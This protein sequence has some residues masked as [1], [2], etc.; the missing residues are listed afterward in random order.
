MDQDIDYSIS[1]ITKKVKDDLYKVMKFGEKRIFTVSSN[2]IPEKVMNIYQ[3]QLATYDGDITQ[4]RGL[5]EKTK[6]YR[7]TQASG[8][9]L[10]AAVTREDKK[11]DILQELLST[12]GYYVNSVNFEGDTPLHL[13]AMNGNIDALD[14]LIKNF[15]AIDPLSASTLNKQTPLHYAITYNKLIA[16][17]KLIANGASVCLQDGDGS[18]AFHIAVAVSSPNLDILDTL[19]LAD[20]SK[21]TIALTLRD[22]KGQTP[23]HEAILNR[24]PVEFL[25]RL[26]SSKVEI[27]NIKDD[28]GRT[29]L[30]FA[31]YVKKLDY[32][33]VLLKG[34]ASKT[35]NINLQD[36][37]GCTAMHYAVKDSCSIAIIQYLHIQGGIDLNTIKDKY[38]K[39]AGDYAKNV[40]IKNYFKNPPNI[41]NNNNNNNTT[42]VPLVITNST[43][44][45]VSSSTSSSSS[46]P[47][48]LDSLSPAINLLYVIA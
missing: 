30:H 25:T 17:K 31:V 11:V 13:A 15:A 24:V 10:C 26:L 2:Q 27:V 32:L 18:T 22:K 47:S 20:S 36:E 23:L 46:S 14:L 37:G 35:I 7:D 1:V 42:N 48:S 6:S 28:K 16:V 40:E 33:A 9:C 8:G 44:T 41:N 19:L 29:P 38:G 21:S 12:E 43:T 34:I 39:T 4:V 5:L 45:I 3:L